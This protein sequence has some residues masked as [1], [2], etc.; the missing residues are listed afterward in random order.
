MASNHLTPMGGGVGKTEGSCVC[1]GV[2]RKRNRHGEG[3][4]TDQVWQLVTTHEWFV[5]M[6]GG[7][8]EAW[9]GRHQ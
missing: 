2:S 3:I 9:G 7:G 6:E 4:Y 1:W 5:L 8:M